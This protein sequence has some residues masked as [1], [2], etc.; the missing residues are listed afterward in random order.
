MTVRACV[1]ACVRVCVYVRM[2]VYVR[3]CVC[4][5]PNT[6]H[7]LSRAAVFLLRRAGE[8]RT[9]QTELAAKAQYV[10]ELEVILA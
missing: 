2:C 7:A 6:A 1:R 8:C 3:V 4:V 9:L 10:E 5:A